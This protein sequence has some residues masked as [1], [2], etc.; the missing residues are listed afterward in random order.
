[1][2]L[3]ARLGFIKPLL[4][5]PRYMTHLISKKLRLFRRYRWLEKN[6]DK[7]GEVLPPLVYELTLTLKCNLRCHMCMLWGDR[8]WCG[9]SGGGK[10]VEEL[11]LNIIKEILLSARGANPS[12]I[13]HGGEPF[14]HSHFREI[15]LMFKQNKFSSIVCTNGTLLKEFQ[16]LIS[17]NPFLDLLI[18]L[19]GLEKENDAIRGKGVYKKV[20]D[21]I[22]F[23]KSLKQPSHIGIQFTILPENVGIIYDFC[24]EMVRLGVDWILLNPCWF[25]AEEQKQDYEKFMM[26]NFNISPKTH[27]GYFSK[28]AIDTD[29]FARQYKKVKSEKWPIQISCYFGN[30]AED[31]YNYAVNPKIFTGNT[32]CYKQWVRMDVMPDGK[33]APCIRY[34]DLIVGDLNKN[35]VATIWNCPDLVK[36]RKIIREKPLPICNK[37]NC[38]YLYDAKRKY[39]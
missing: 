33:V 28:Y 38:L 24:K 6:I 39:L 17:G 36:F 13:L 19:D 1:M 2:A 7:D 27:L 32:F 21:N 37:C 5:Q 31:I 20:T 14:L 16:D 3:S 18:S 30:P 15:A 34:P 8:G 25:V 23:V 29:E 35:D 10:H 9:T 11:D 22:K 4:K 12:F 26:E